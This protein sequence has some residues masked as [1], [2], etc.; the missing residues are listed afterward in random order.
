[1]SG[2]RM[3]DSYREAHIPL[4]QDPALRGMYINFWNSVRFG[5]IMED[6]DTMA[7]GAE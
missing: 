4:G 1:M 5:R 7:G 6:L 2:R 3:Q